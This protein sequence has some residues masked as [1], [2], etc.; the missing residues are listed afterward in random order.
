MDRGINEAIVLAGGLGTRLRS[1]IG[2]IPKPLAPVNDHP[3][4]HYLFEYL[5]KNQINVAILSVG[6]K[7]EMIHEIFGDNYLGIEIKYA[8][9]EE[10]LGTGGGI[11]LALEMV[12]GAQCYVLNGDTYFDI[13]L[14]ILGDF[15]NSKKSEFTLAGKS[16]THFDRYGT[17]DIDQDGTILAFNE[18]MP[19][20][21]GVINGGIY[22]VNKDILE[23][24]QK[25]RFSIETDYLE[26][27]AGNGKLKAMVFHDYF[28]DIGTPEDY[29]Q[30]ELD[31][32]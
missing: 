1:T 12:D 14:A 9:E 4:L 23:N 7:W 24:F 13:Q 21:E 31:H 22:C 11:K 16:M 15:H 17:I 26:P 30:F 19:K 25:V 29:R 2:E 20:K 3:F 5:K 8:V 10:P 6:Y 18:K 32:K 28:K 27:N